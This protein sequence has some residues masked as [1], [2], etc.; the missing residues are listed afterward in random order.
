MRDDTQASQ[1][2]ALGQDLDRRLEQPDIAAELVDDI[3]LDSGLLGLGQ[4]RQSADDR[5]QHAAAIDIADQH[6][7]HIRCLGKAHIGNVAGA[8]S[9][10]GRRTGALDQHQIGLGR[11]PVPA[12]QHLGQQLGFERLIVARLGAAEDAALHDDLGAGRRL[13]LQQHR[14]HVGDRG[15]AA[16]P[17]LQ[18]LGPADLAALC[19]DGG[20]VRHV[21]R[22]ERPDRETAPGEGAAQAGRNQRLADIGAGALQHQGRHR[23]RPAGSAPSAIS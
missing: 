6:H 20:V 5:G 7:G 18:R 15:H 17:R 16:G 22:L 23:R 13:R 14:V 2:G 12:F 4:Q 9:D 11:E 10:L 1:A 3:A 19:R 8:Q 21:L